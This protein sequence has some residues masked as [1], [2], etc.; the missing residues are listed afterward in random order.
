M[1]FFFFHDV[2]LLYVGHVAPD[3]R[4]YGEGA[5]EQC[6]DDKWDEENKRKT[7]P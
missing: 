7:I 6:E 3:L 1:E 2:D 5:R 4:P